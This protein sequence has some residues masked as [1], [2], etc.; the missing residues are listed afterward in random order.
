MDTEIECFR[1]QTSRRKKRMQ[2]EGFERYLRDLYRL[3]SQLAKRKNN[4]GWEPLVPPVMRG[5]KRFFVLRGDV[6]ESPQAAFFGGIL[7][8]INTVQYSHRKDFTKKGR[9]RGRKI[10]VAT[11]QGLLDAYF[12]LHRRQPFTPAELAFF[13]KGEVWTKSGHFSHFRYVFTEPWRFVLRVEP[14]MITKVRKRDNVL[15][16][17]IDCLRRTINRFRLRPGMHRL[18]YGRYQWKHRQTERLREKNALKNK[19]ISRVLDEH[20]LQLKDEP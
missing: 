9:K 16:S 1:L 18:I 2:H 7:E 10:R 13:E 17:E 14:N 19:P 4:L 8:K 20:Y 12:R 11:H 15:E 3:E 6:A 5:W